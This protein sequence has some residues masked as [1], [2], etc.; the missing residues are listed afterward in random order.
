[1]QTILGSNGQIGYESANELYQNY[2]K[3]LRLVGRHP[4]KIHDT[5][6]VVVADLTDAD[7]AFQAIQGSD[8]VYFT[9]GLPMDT[10]VWEA[11]FLQITEN[12][13]QAAIKTNDK[14]AFFDNTYMYQ[15]DATP[16]TETSPFLPVGRKSVIR[17][18]MATRLLEAMTNEGLEAVIGRAP[19]F[20]GPDRTQGITN[21]M[22]FDRIKAGERPQIPV[23]DTALRTFIWTPDASRALALLGNTPDTYG[24][25]CHLPVAPGISYQ[26]LL[27]LAEKVVGRPIPYD[28]IPLS[29]FQNEATTNRMRAEQLEI[30]VR[31]QFDNVFITDKFMRRFPDFHVT[32]FATGIQ[33]ILN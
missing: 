6:Q 9:V 26:A 5:D 10:S 31:Y 14:L 2:T 4:Q 33:T 22:V 27:A 25:T 21:G 28:V 24:Q 29:V 1:M 18:K 7:Q 30:L 11:Q 19:E 32:S 13:I 12:V 3:E 20:Y 16:Q 8:V 17:A 15:K 23:S